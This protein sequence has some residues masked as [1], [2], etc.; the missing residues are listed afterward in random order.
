MDGRGVS[1]A[2]GG[3]SLLYVEESGS[4]DGSVRSLEKGL[5]VQGAA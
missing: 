5:H 1:M 3:D 4:F 2:D